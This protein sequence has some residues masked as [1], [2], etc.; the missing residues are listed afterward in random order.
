MTGH[1]TPKKYGEPDLEVAGFQMWVHGRQFPDS[2]DSGDGN[3]L[4]VTA[5]CGGPGA[6]VWASGAI[7]EVTYLVLWADQC[8]ALANGEAQQAELAPAD[9]A[10]RVLIRQCELGQH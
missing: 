5:H 1:P 4:Y 10:L 3:W 8:A 6:N 9:P 2:M 7:L